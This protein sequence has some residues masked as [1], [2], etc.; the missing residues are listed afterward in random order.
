ML[1]T[2]K[3]LLICLILFS[4][5]ADV[6]SQVNQ[7]IKNFEVLWKTFDERYA[8]FELKGIDWDSV[9]TI[10]R[11]QITTQTEDK[12]LFRI[13]CQ[14][15]Q[16]LTDGHV[17]IEAEHLSGEWECGPPYEFSLEVAFPTDSAQAAFKAVMDK[18]LEAHGFSAPVY[19]ELSEDTHFHYRLS[20]SFGYLRLDEMTEDINFLKFPKAMDEAISAFQSKSA[21]IIDLRFNGGGFDYTSH[22]MARRLIREETFYMERRKRKGKSTYTSVRTR[23]IKPTQKGTFSKPIVILTSD[24]TASAAEIFLLLMK[25]LEHV[26]LI[27]EASEGIFSDTFEFSLPN[28]WEVSL[29][30]QQYFSQDSINYEGKGIPVDI[31]V[32]NSPQDL[33]SQKDPVIETAIEYLSGKIED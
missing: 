2:P 21:I 13:C 12:D 26:T 19:R 1:S 23:R 14:M 24:Y 31:Q 16:T 3:K 25:D 4:W 8:N 18:S 29:S 15:L 11:P 28:K 20:D 7:P 32:S 6:Y 33:L 22:M 27:G 9:Y 30:H 5:G 17:S 10:Y